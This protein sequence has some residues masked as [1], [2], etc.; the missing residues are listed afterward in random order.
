MSYVATKTQVK[1]LE[2]LSRMNEEVA[3]KVFIKKMWPSAI[4]DNFARHFLSGLVTSN[5]VKKGEKKGVET[6]SITPE[7]QNVLARPEW[8]C[9]YCKTEFFEMP[10]RP[11][12]KPCRRCGGEHPVCKE[13]LKV[14][15]VIG[16]EW[17]AW[18]PSLRN[19][20]RRK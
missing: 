19:C 7:G 1:A 2:I 6:Y 5:Y 13:C 14:Q 4:A 18:K 11:N 3:L 15:V 10:H 16:G 8:C 9:A 17:P 12:P 20:P